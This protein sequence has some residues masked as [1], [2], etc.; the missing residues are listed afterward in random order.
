MWGKG[1]FE[2][3]RLLALMFG[4]GLKFNRDHEKS[5]T[6]EYGIIRGHIGVL[7]DV[8]SGC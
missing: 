4:T 1:D 7:P 8:V 6:R 3:G 5:Y 2:D